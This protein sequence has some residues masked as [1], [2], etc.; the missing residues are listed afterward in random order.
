MLHIIIFII[1]YIVLYYLF[2]FKFMNCHIDN[3]FSLFI[4]SFSAILL[5]RSIKIITQ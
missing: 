5:T 4:S 1:I 2:L 3:N